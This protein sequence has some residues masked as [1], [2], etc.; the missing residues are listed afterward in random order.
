[1]FGG[2]REFMS[3]ARAGS[4]VLR[5][6]RWLCSSFQGLKPLATIV[7][8]PDAEDS[9]EIISLKRHDVPWLTLR[10]ATPDKGNVRH[11]ALNSVSVN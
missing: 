8:P 5:T 11:R 3:D 10:H 2:A 4:C 1:V 6:H 7:R 9:G